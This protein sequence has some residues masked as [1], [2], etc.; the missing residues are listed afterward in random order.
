M[1]YT[2]DIQR[3]NAENEEEIIVECKERKVLSCLTIQ[4]ILCILILSFV[5]I[6]KELVPDTFEQLSSQ[7]SNY[8]E[9]SLLLE[10]GEIR[11]VDEE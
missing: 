11:I 1:Q 2:Q 7:Y 9:Q 8:I 3:I 10:D 6:L 4:V 5:L